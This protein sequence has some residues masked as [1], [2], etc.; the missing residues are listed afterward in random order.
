MTATAVGIDLLS[1]KS[2]AGGHPVEQYRWLRENAPVY[3][4]EEPDG[5]GFWAITDYELVR[6][7]SKAPE[8]FSSAEGGILLTDFPPEE[9]EFFR[10]MMLAMD[11][12]K[13]SFYR[14]LVGGLFTPKRAALWIDSISDTVRSI[15][16]EVCEWG[17]CDLVLD[18]AGKL[19]SYVIAE[20]VG[21]PRADG[22]RLYELTE[23]MHSAPDAVTEEQRSA[24]MMEIIGYAN[25]V[26]A[27]K[28]EKQTDDLASRLVV[29]E[30]DGQRLTEQEFASFFMLLVNA[31]GDTT[32]NLIGGATANLL[33]RPD[34]LARLRAEMPT[35]MPTAVDELLRFQS[36]VIYMRRTLMSD[37]ELG[38]VRL[39]KGDKV[40]LYYGAANRD[41]KVFER[42]D[43]LVLDR[44]PNEHVAFGGGGAHFCLGS[45]FGRIEINQMMS[46]LLSRFT[47]LEAT[48]EPTWLA[49]SFISGPTNLPVKYTPHKPVGA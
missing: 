20:L 11:P 41:D 23:I 12:P 48:A 15:L 42:P 46:Q 26:R 34:T 33:R 44:T 8:V 24:A 5:P 4:H 2:F 10:T 7:A 6:Q 14:R 21:I 19:P 3:R 40:A 36:P 25:Q 13:H 29:A 9:L 45:H 35:L 31:G 28:L 1:S 32:R 30:V 47:D 37:T 18:I 38:G 17:E 27:D 39:A 22:V 49:S 16:D 43:E